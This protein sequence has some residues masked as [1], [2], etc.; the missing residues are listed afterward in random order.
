M[1]RRLE[2]RCTLELHQQQALVA[3]P[4]P[5]VLQLAGAV[6]GPF[7]ATG[8]AAPPLLDAAVG[9]D[10]QGGD[11]GQRGVFQ[12]LAVGHLLV[13]PGA[14]QRRVL[15]RVWRWWGRCHA[16][17]HRLAQQRLAVVRI[18]RGQAGGEHVVGVVGVH[19]GQYLAGGWLADLRLQGLAV[20]AA[21]DAEALLALEVFAFHLLLMAAQDQLDRALVEAALVA[22]VQFGGQ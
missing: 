3:A 9:A 18:T 19:V 2:F 1:R 16:L 21:G 4:A 8:H 10:A 11:H 14:D 20:E 13:H 22:A 6:V 15:V 17:E 5:A 12:A 7:A